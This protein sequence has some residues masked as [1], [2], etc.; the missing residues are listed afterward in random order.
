[1]SVV[2]PSGYKPA[3]AGLKRGNK[4]EDGWLDEV[5]SP[6]LVAG[7][8][9]CL[10]QCPTDTRKELI[11]NILV[12]GDIAEI[13]PNLGH[14]LAL[15]LKDALS[16]TSATLEIFAHREEEMPTQG[17]TFFPLAAQDLN[18]LEEHVGF[19]SYAPHRAD[20]ISWVGGSVYSSLW[21]GRDKQDV[22]VPWIFSPVNV[23]EGNRVFS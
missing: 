20:L 3:A 22:F 10:K 5:Y 17:V 21:L 9:N 18:S 14:C 11:A 15:K 16:D 7:L 12:C 1:M 13:F 6:G 8:L 4:E 23:S 2:L 19:L